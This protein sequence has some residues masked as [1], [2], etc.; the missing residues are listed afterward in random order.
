MT[1]LHRNL[2][3]PDIELL[4]CLVMWVWV[5]IELIV[6]EC[7]HWSLEESTPTGATAHPR[8]CVLFC[9][10]LVIV[11]F[12]R[13]PPGLFHWHWG[14]MIA[15]VPVK[16]PWRIWVS[17]S[18]GS[19]KNWP[20]YNH[21]NP[22]PNRTCMLISWIVLQNCLGSDSIWICIFLTRIGN[23]IVEIRLTY[24]RLISTMGFPVAVGQHLYMGQVIKV[25]L[26]CYLVLLSND[27]KNR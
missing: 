12:Y 22:K 17:G 8:V 24:D 7:C 27:S 14:N 21:I 13:Y 10:G 15:P 1:L 18:H 11:D 23:P 19:K 20:K 26:S 9:C 3:V 5:S 2:T 25:W 4:G 6:A 16:Q